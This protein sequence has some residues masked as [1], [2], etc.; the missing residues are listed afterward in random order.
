M[1]TENVDRLKAAQCRAARALLGITQP[2][3]AAR[4]GLGLSTVVD[5]EK[6]RR[7][8][9]AEAI[10]AIRAALE[11]AGIQFIEENGGGAGVRM[12]KPR[13]QK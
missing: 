2:D 3:L 7:L 12:R 4:A 8:V 6:G 5:F 13:N 10:Q 11:Y 9:S 1:S